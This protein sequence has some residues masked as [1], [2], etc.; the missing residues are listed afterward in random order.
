LDLIVGA[1]SSRDHAYYL[2][3]S[4]MERVE[5]VQILR[6]KYFKFHGLKYREDGTANKK[7]TLY[8]YFFCAMPLGSVEVADV[9]LIQ[10][11]KATLYSFK[12]FSQTPLWEFKTSVL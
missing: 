3:L 2:G 7:Q 8:L 1:A 12:A 5:I 10:P 6:E 4:G 9:R 11:V